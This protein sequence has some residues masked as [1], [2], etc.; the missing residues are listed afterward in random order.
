MLVLFMVLLIEF[1]INS[2]SLTIFQETLIIM[3]C[4]PVSRIIWNDPLVDNTSVTLSLL[5]APPVR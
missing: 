1:V 2:R 4:V 3:S 5:R